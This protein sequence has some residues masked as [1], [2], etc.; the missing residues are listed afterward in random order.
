VY[1]DKVTVKKM[2]KERI[3][4]RIK[5]KIKGTYERPRVYVFKSNRYVYT[6]V[7]DDENGR[8]LASAS[9]LDK[10]FKVKNKNYKNIEACQ[11][12]GGVL[13]K[14]LKQKKIESVV[15]DRGIYPYHGRIRAIAEA[16][17]KGGLVF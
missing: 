12:L 14:K 1:K 2:A 13:A 15:F 17:R 10:E 16:M 4:K 3:R 11:V 9:T 6:Q 7:I 5:K 8:I